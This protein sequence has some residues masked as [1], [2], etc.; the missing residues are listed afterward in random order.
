MIA[1]TSVGLIG[2][3]DVSAWAEEE[4]A[5][6]NVTDLLVDLAALRGGGADDIDAKMRAIS[7]VNDDEGLG[8]LEMGR[9]A[10]RDVA[11]GLTKG[12]FSSIDAA[13][14][15][16]RVARSAPLV[17]PELRPFIGL[18]SEWDDDPSNRELY[19]EEIRSL[20]AAFSDTRESKIV[21]SR[22]SSKVSGA[23]GPGEHANLL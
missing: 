5:A 21:D 10:A 19:E 17:E 7:S 13:R 20:A 15:L 12:E 8:E 4:L 23:Q 6:G 11:M 22:A 18:A 14:M 1:L 2:P 3:D 16:W 9:L